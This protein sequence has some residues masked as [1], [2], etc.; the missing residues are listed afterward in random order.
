MADSVDGEVNLNA[1]MSNMNDNL[2]NTEVPTIDRPGQGDIQAENI[3]VLDE[4]HGTWNMEDNSDDEE[5]KRICILS[6]PEKK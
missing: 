1:S 5:E 4:K 2:E 3:P 6:D